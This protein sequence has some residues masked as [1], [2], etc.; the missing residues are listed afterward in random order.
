[1]TNY[2]IEVRKAKEEDFPI[3]Q[4]LLKQTA[5]WLQSIGSKQ[6]SGILEGKDNHN[7]P[8]A[9]KRG[10]VYLGYIEEDPVGMFVMW[11]HQSAWDRELWG[12]DDTDGYFYLHRLNVSRSFAG[13]GIASQLLEK[14]L[15]EAHKAGK[16]AVR[17]DCIEKNKYLNQFYQKAGF[18]KIRTVEDHD[19]GEQI[20]NFNLYEKSVK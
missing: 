19:A 13:K 18:E 2:S 5:E 4:S 8:E 7:T 15:E 14:G 17:L 9:V 12:Q 3:V 11:D 1:M 6:W 20:A 16:K 10:E